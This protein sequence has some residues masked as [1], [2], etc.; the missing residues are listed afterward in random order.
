M[1]YN[2]KQSTLKMVKYPEWWA[3]FIENEFKFLANRIAFTLAVGAFMKV[4]IIHPAAF[5][6]IC[7]GKP[8]IVWSSL[9]DFL[10]LVAFLLIPVVHVSMER[11]KF[12]NGFG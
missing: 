2:G 4:D 8:R 6:L 9:E 12:G 3:D 10:L 1:R 7:G 11:E 5:L